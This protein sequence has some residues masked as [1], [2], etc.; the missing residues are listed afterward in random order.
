MSATEIIQR[1]NDVVIA[2]IDVERKLSIIPTRT[3]KF[4]GY[5]KD[6]IFKVNRIVMD[7]NPF[8]PQIT[9][10]IIP[11]ENGSRIHVLMF[12]HPVIGFGVTSIILPFAYFFIN[13]L[14]TGKELSGT[15]EVNKWAY[16]V[17]L[18]LIGFIYGVTMLGFKSESDNAKKFFARLFEIQKQ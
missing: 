13:V 18:I 11:T 5:V 8:H 17:P 4:E 6:N 7:K 16:I 12:P 10:R 2:K 1:L 15:T 14:I 3:N 9:G